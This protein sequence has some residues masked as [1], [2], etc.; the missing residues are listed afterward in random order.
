[1]PLH[2]SP[3]S[4]VVVRDEQWR[5]VH[6]DAFERCAV[7][8]LE[9]G[10]RRLQVIDPFDRVTPLTTQRIV[11]RRRCRVMATA[12]DAVS[13]ARPPV[14]LW[15]AARSSI[16]LLPYQLAPALAVLRGATR[17]LLADA[18]GLGKTI[19]AGLIL[20]ELCERS[21]VERALVLCPAGLRATWAQEL[22][23]RFGMP[24]AVFDHGAI[25]EAIATLPPGVNPWTMHRTV[26]ASIDFAKRAEVLAAIAAVPLDILIV[27]EAHHL[28][29]GT[30]RGA[31]V[32]VLAARSP[33][34]VLVSATPHSGDDTAFNF[35]TAL[36]AHRDP[37][38]IFRRSR[39]DVGIASSR[40][41]RLMRIRTSHDESALLAAVDDYAQAIWC[42]RG[43]TDAAVRL[44]AITIAR[45]AASS[46]FALEQTLRRRLALLGSNPEPQQRT[47][48]WE[49]VDEADEDGSPLLLA[50]LGLA[51]EDAERIAIS[52]LL[53]LIGHCGTSSKL[54]WLSRALGRLREPVIVFTEYRDTLD[55]ITRVLPS[56]RRA[57]WLYGAM[58]IDLRRAAV[59]AFNKGDTDILLATDAAGE[60]LSLHHRCRLVIDIE[61][62]WSPMRL[63]QRFGRVDRLGQR[64]RVHAWRLY[65]PRTIEERV[66]E[67]LRLRRRR[68]ESAEGLAATDEHAVA[69]DVLGSGDP[70]AAPAPVLETA[71]IGGVAEEQARL[72]RQ[73]Q[74]AGGRTDAGIAGAAP[75]SRKTAQLTALH[76]VTYA[77]AVGS[78][79]A[80]Q[81]C[82][83][84]VLV[85][86]SQI[87]RPRDAIAAVARA[88][89]LARSLTN[90][91]ETQCAAIDRSLSAIRRS[92]GARI[93]S[94]RGQ[95]SQQSL[96]EVQQSLF[97]GRALAAA[98]EHANVLTRLDAWLS[99]RQRSLE[100]PVRP[101]S[102]SARLIAVWPADRR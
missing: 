50:R 26:V 22:R 85:D 72:T 15:T 45:R 70:R 81:P 11:R 74:R 47:L 84:L 58:P 73:R 55:A 32:A 67:R 28:T 10:G 68:A 2:A 78:I 76:V 98:R 97:D 33:W 63:E 19:Q 38:T 14:A 99:R 60:G 79:V 61:L 24:C 3:G 52:H 86:A 9:A 51:S 25:G 17:I 102:A 57:G 83:H 96:A 5:V 12:L 40:R 42:A 20:S 27:D 18:V 21:L 23:E 53:A 101:E 39:G 71:A 44:V 75:R 87:S 8:T 94:I 95:I 35:L 65:H 62:P 1:M 6:V 36:G 46:L 64:R 13:L 82:A 80:E 66:L 30:D 41:E 59:D 89:L 34:C 43:A 16:E 90:H 69:A 88:P 77:N 37:I 54:E 49:E 93:A 48:P 7:V 100:A 92:A 56:N 31:A 91:I 4:T 29:P